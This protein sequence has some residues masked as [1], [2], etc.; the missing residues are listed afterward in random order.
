MEVSV[1]PFRN[2][3]CMKMEVPVGKSA[4]TEVFWGMRIFD[5]SG[6]FVGR[7]RFGDPGSFEMRY[8]D[9]AR[10]KFA[11]ETVRESI[12]RNL[13]VGQATD[14]AVLLKWRSEKDCPEVAPG[15]SFTEG[16]RLGVEEARE[17]SAVVKEPPEWLAEPEEPPRLTGDE[18]N[19][20]WTTGFETTYRRLL[21]ERFKHHQ[22]PVPAP[23]LD[24]TDLSQVV[25]HQQGFEL[26][27]KQDEWLPRL[28]A[29]QLCDKWIEKR[30]FA[31]QPVKNIISF[32]N[33]FYEGM[34]R[35]FPNR[36]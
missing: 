1:W 18:F 6:A 3:A 11:P 14:P 13:W 29:D 34:E 17:S 32:R 28:L 36:Y 15:Q 23:K 24:P 33:G 10:K 27:Q 26:A 20:G 9:G 25:S 19:D 16:H 22:K 2:M 31:G 4:I 21:E 8:P 35:K 12:S 5:S 7:L 30:A